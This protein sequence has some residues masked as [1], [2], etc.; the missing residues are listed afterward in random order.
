MIVVD[1][2]SNKDYI[3]ISVDNKE[4]SKRD[5]NKIF[6]NLVYINVRG[7]VCSETPPRITNT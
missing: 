5:G 3:E 7:S 6:E 1:D 4:E 2:D